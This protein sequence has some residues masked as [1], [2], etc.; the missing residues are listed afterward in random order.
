MKEKW[1]GRE[2]EARRNGKRTWGRGGE[3]ELLLTREFWRQALATASDQRLPFLAQVMETHPLLRFQF[4]LKGRFIFVLQCTSS[5][6]MPW[7][8]GIY[9]YFLL[10]HSRYKVYAWR[11]WRV[12]TVKLARSCEGR[13]G[14][15]AGQSMLVP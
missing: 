6:A 13:C 1:K 15:P 8:T 11:G 2:G 9:I 5:L 14:E 12:E 4:Q 3:E 7:K 10:L